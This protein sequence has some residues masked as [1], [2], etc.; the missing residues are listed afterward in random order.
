MFSLIRLSILNSEKIKVLY[1]TFKIELFLYMIIFLCCQMK[2]GEENRGK[3]EERERK[4]KT[5]I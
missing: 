3:R 5:N 1:S 4:D 2:K